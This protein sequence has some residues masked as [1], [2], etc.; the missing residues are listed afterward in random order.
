MEA[1]AKHMCL[2]KVGRFRP[3]SVGWRMQPKRKQELETPPKGFVASQ[4][5]SAKKHNLW[6]QTG[7]TTRLTLQVAADVTDPKIM[8][9]ISG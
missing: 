8:Y 4:D 6:L 5:D 2:Q 1:N 7:Q 3:D 9:V